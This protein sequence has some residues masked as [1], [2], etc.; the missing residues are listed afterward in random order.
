MSG[1]WNHSVYIFQRNRYN[2]PAIKLALRKH[3]VQLQQ[4]YVV[5]EQTL[6][7]PRFNRNGQIARLT[8]LNNVLTVLF[9]L[10]KG[11]KSALLP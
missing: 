10:L 8:T 9:Y 11:V 1:W 6:T 2:L 5:A 4:G 3:C 7:N